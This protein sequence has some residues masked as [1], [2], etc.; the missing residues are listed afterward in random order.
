MDY[1]N[2]LTAITFLSNSIML[3]IVFKY[4]NIQTWMIMFLKRKVVRKSKY[5]G[6]YALKFFFHIWMHL[7]IPCLGDAVNFFLLLLV[8]NQCIW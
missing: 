5:L 4:L 7:D 2:I 6:A 3:T 8:V 1:V